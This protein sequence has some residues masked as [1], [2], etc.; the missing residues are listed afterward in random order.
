[1][2]QVVWTEP[3]LS[4]LREIAEYIALDKES[5][6]KRFVQEVFSSVERLGQFPK[7]GRKPP[8]LDSKTR[9]REIIIGPSRVL[10]R[11]FEDKVYILYVMRGEQQLRKYLIDD[12]MKDL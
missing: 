10:Y 3:A 8:E 7:S 9:Y 5:A 1:M 11:F 4:D 6:A 12:R 2:A